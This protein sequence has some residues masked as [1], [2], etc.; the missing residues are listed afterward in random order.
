LSATGTYTFDGNAWLVDCQAQRPHNQLP[1]TA[2][3]A[4]LHLQVLHDLPNF[5]LV[6]H[7]YIGFIYDL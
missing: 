5:L 1:S 7:C 6:R 4:Q 3:S 2:S